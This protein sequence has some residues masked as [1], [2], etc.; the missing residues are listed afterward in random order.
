MTDYFSFSA[1]D[2]KQKSVSLTLLTSE[3]LERFEATLNTTA[4]LWLKHTGFKAKS[5]QVCHLPA[6]DAS[7]QAVLIGIGEHFDPSLMSSIPHRLEPGCYSFDLS[8]IDASEHEIELA[9]LFW[10]LGSY[11]YSQYQVVEESCAQLLVPAEID[12]LKLESWVSSYSLARDMINTPCADMGPPDIEQLIRH[13]ADEHDATVTVI[14]GEQLASDYPAIH[15]VGKGAKDDYAPRLIDLTWGDENAPKITLVGKGVCFDTGGL[16]LKPPRGMRLMKKDMGGSASA[17]A[18]ARTIMMQQWPVRL[19]LMIPA[20]ENAIDNKSY[21]PGD[22]IK[23]RAGITVEVDNTDAEGR[24][25]LCD[26]LYEACSES[27]DYLIDFATLTG[28]RAVAL[29]PDYAAVFSNQ[30]QLAHEVQAHSVTEHDLVWP[31]PLHRP[32]NAMLSSTIADCQ[33]CSTTGEA[34][35]ITAALFL[36]KFVAQETAWLHFD[37]PGMHEHALEGHKKGG[38]I[39]GVR[40]VAAYLKKKLDI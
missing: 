39:E 15:A 8:H 21:R 3:S 38:D 7:L 32:Y 4:K 27:P 37:I 18:L 13:V 35:T 16:N 14:S 5:K 30:S 28:A 20:V 17:I 22:I 2:H 11:R 24:L 36:D 33:N 29:G 23:T 40:A 19:R 31:L 6:D 26:A 12:A 34:G 10:G 1:E 9:Y 25:I